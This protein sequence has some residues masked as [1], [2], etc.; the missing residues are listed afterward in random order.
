R[1]C[2]RFEELYGEPPEFV[3]RAPGRVNIIGEHIDYCGFPVLPMAIE[4]DCL[5]AVRATNP[6]SDAQRTVMLAN[7]DAD[8]YEPVS[9]AYQPG[10]VV[11]IDPKSHHWSNYF[12]SGYKGAIE[13]IGCS[14]PK[15]M[16]CLMD[17]NVPPGAGLSS[18]SALVCCA[19]LATMKA[20]GNMLPMYDIV[21]TAAECE[22]YVGTC[23]GGMDQACS[24]MAQEGSALFVEFEPTLSAKY[25]FL[26]Q[27]IPSL[28]FVIADTLVVCKK[29]VTA[30]MRYNLRVVETRAGALILA[31][32]LGIADHP[33]CVGANPLTYKGVMDV[34]FAINNRPSRGH[35]NEVSV[36]IERLQEMNCAIE[37]AFADYPDGYTLHDIAASL[38]MTLDELR[39]KLH[40]SQ[41]PVHA[42]QFQLLK[43]ARHVYSEAMRVAKFRQICDVMNDSSSMDPKV[44]RSLG[45]LMYESQ[46]SCHYNYD[47]SC[48][49]IDELCAIAREAGSLGS[50]LTGAGWGGSTVHLVPSPYVKH[51]IARVKDRYYRQRFPHLSEERLSQAVFATSPGAGAKITDYYTLKRSA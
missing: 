30:A 38:S 8:K 9:F 39:A 26:P 49:E 35:R 28:C 14:A 10:A 5:I 51:F 31:R 25:V 27:T 24:I 29:A 47:C 17:E 15:A 1:L 41:F 12:K 6:D 4:H 45:N 21:K 43:R 3:A 32:H 11:E 40:L 7:I 18:S 44:L 19:V 2:K 48:P 33:S 42:D 22:E 13:A 46:V 50:R 36:W 16:M 23:G 37:A 34:Y 20:N